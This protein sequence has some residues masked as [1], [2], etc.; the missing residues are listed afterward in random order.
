MGLDAL[1]RK[2]QRAFNIIKKS[3]QVVIL[4]AHCFATA[5]HA[6]YV[7]KNRNCVFTAI[8]YKCAPESFIAP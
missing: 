8:F 4:P 2:S 3:V 1:N 7:S 5:H 6:A